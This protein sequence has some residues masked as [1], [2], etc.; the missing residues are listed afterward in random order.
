[1]S[2][3]YDWWEDNQNYWNAYEK[4]ED[5][6][7]EERKLITQID[8][9]LEKIQS[10]YKIIKE[11]LKAENK[12]KQEEGKLKANLDLFDLITEKHSKMK[13]LDKEKRK[14]LKMLSDI[15]GK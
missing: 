14:I 2:H 15:K 5:K 4:Y 10:I 13:Q 7:N 6:I 1:M 9:E 8:K 3:Q 11:L 12:T